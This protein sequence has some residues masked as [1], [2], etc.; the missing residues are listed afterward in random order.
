MLF[1]HSAGIINP[2]K[3]NSAISAHVLPSSTLPSWVG[4]VYKL[5]DDFLSTLNIT[6]I[7]LADQALVIHVQLFWQKHVTHLCIHLAN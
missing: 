1:L 5:D 4:K 3:S 6:P 2:G 7:T